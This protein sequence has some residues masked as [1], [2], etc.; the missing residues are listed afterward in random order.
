MS[1]AL[2]AAEPNTDRIETLDFLRGC[3]LFGILL[4]N[5]TGMGLAEAYTNPM[6]SGGATG[7]DLWAWIVTQV[8]FE[9]TQRAIFSML[10]G[11]GV[12]L[13]TSRAERAGRPDAVDLFLRRTLWLIAFGLVNAWVLLWGGDI[14]YFYGITGLFVVAFRKLPARTLLTIGLAGLLFNTALGGYDSWQFH[15]AQTEAAAAAALQK[16]GKPL[17]DEQKGAIEAWEKKS[18][19]YVAKTKDVAEETKKMQ[20]GYV[21]A[22]P[23][24]TRD[25]SFMESWFLYRFFFDVFAMMVIG[26]ALLKA[27][28][29]TLEAPARLYWAMMAGGYAI[30]LATN[31]YETRLIIDSGFTATAF[32]RADITYDVG[33]LGMTAGH[34]GLLLLFCRSGL[35]GWF[36]RSMAAVGR[37]ALTNY[38]THSVMALV[39][40]VLLG[41][42]GRFARH[43]LYYI[44]FAVWAFQLIVSPIWLRHFRFGPVEWLW[45]ALTYGKAPAFR[46]APAVEPRLAAA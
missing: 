32:A 26:M 44:V 10:F 25:V 27:G 28:V 42:F 22:W 40:F 23:R 34:L 30:G 3:A 8:G 33:R 37:M 15:K 13:F 4:M 5:I 7:A 35:F 2:T 17:S 1:E 45:R 46:R 12:L 29:L 6:N 36:R 19:R 21:S 16:A 38:L 9:G 14:L 39:L 43:E 11:A 20:S 41:Q 18:E 31:I 24:V